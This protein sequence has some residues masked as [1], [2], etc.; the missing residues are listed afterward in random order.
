MRRV[1]IVDDMLPNTLLLKGYMKG[2]DRIEPMTFTDPVK[3]LTCC[4]DV[5]PDL[6][7]LDY[8]MPGMNGLDFLKRFRASE[9][10]RDVPVV[11]ITG[12][13]KKDALYAALKAG[14]NDF[15]RKPVDEIELATRVHNL[16]ELCSR[17]RDL[18]MAN[19]QLY[20]L[21]TTDQLTTLKN[22]RY[23]LEKLGV[24]VDRGCRYGRPC[25]V[26]L[27]DADRFKFINDK[28]GHDIGDMALR[29]LSQV[30]VDELRHVDHIGRMGGDEFAVQF[31][32]TARHDALEVC[33]RL[34]SRI[35]EATVPVG[36]G[37]INL[38]AS[39][40][41]TEIIQSGDEPDA[42]MKR[43]DQALYRA[44]ELGRDRCEMA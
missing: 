29:T 10:F 31:P 2:L 27:I 39:M 26:A 43:A 6:V 41:L 12:E 16:L 32:E 19:A 17:Q 8:H 5:V 34:L 7:L 24:E 30:L 35:R 1:L 36:T 18:A 4:D 15:L 37:E 20:V 44:K 21:A 13:E 23:F 11:M 3:A 33:R 22:R 40:G 28:Y 25:S 42:V 9:R 38:T 14:A